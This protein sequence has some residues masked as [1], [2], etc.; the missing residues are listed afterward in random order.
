MLQDWINILSSAN[1]QWVMFGAAFLGLASGVVGSFVLLRK[2]SLVGDAMA[3]AALPGIC[4]GFFLYGREV[5]ALMAGAALTGLIA[6][7]SI[8]AITAH[9]RLK[10]DAAIGIVLSVFFGFGIV[11]LT[12]ITNSSGGNKA[13]LDEFIFG[14]AASLVAQDVQIL[15][16]AAI[17]LL[18]VSLLFFKELKLLTFDPLF[19]GGLGLP[20]T[21]LNGLLSSM[22]VLIVITGIQAV[23][24]V[25][26]AAMLIT[27]AIAARYWT[28]HL[29]LMA[30]LA[31]SIGAFSGGFGA[32]TSAAVT[33]LPTGPVIV[34]TATVFFLFS[35]FFA[36]SRGL[37][38]RWIRNH[39]NDKVI[40]QERVLRAVYDLLEERYEKRNTA[41]SFNQEEL[42]QLTH[43]PEQKLA[44]TLAH[45][46]KRNLAILTEDGKYQLT[47]QGLKQ[48][49]QSSLH[50]RIQNVY[51][52]YESE[53][54]NLGITENQNYEWEQTPP[55]VQKRIKELLRRENLEPVSLQSHK[56]NLDH[57]D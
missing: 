46:Q 32:I 40:W 36:P 26:M 24:V 57:G 16:G 56:A 17:L 1:L 20:V 13:G 9:S 6:I 54:G 3:H 14:Q 21:F 27:P 33:G 53:L 15:L 37:V 38:A 31:G 22:V 43:L 48:A 35:F 51:L 30:V 45:L 55:S 8:R 41:L 11:L 42:S 49:Y 39:K 52:M 2:E 19:A 50:Y 7:Y 23:G 25:L 18:S 10:Q 34:I 28:E 47:N 29:G 5:F 12:R 4:F 44:Q